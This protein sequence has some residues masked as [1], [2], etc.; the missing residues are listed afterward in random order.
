MEGPRIVIRFS[1]GGQILVNANW[2]VEINGGVYP[3]QIEAFADFLIRYQ[4]IE[5]NSGG[6]PVDTTTLIV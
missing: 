5:M 4:G 3:R 6:G 2:S 1:N